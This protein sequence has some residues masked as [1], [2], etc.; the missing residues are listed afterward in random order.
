MALHHS[1]S[2]KKV[3][4]TGGGKG[5]GRQ[6]V[7]RFHDDGASVFTIDKDPEC[8]Q[9]LKQELP[10]VTAEVADITDW[11]GTRKVVASFGVLDHLVNS[12]GIIII[13]KF[14][15]IS[16]DNMEKQFNINLAAMINVSQVMAKGLIDSGRGGS[17]VNIA[18][19][20]SRVGNPVGATIYSI[21]KAGVE[22]LTKSMAIEL[23]PHN[24]RV[25]AVSPGF[26]ETPLLQNVLVGLEDFAESWMQRLISKRLITPNEIADLVMFLLSPLS[27]MIVGESVLVDGGYRAT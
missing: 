11:D 8:I 25:N 27:S 18:S 24:I 22:N 6:L 20:L 4:I 19:V 1:F 23:G 14:M 12:A 9:K 15:D 21:T 5:I 26:V 17:I 7:Q 2:G 3:L 10:S 16:K 13:E